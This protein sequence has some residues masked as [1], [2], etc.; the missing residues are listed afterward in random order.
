MTCLL[1]KLSTDYYL[2][3]PL[4]SQYLEM[5]LMSTNIAC[6][7]RPPAE[8][9]SKSKVQVRHGQTDAASNSR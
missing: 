4:L 1:A 9:L 7:P 2:L 8:C 6:S 3:Q 5:T